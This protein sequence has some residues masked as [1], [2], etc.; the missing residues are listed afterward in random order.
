V[1]G[2]FLEDAGTVGQQDE[3]DVKAIKSG[4]LDNA[5]LPNDVCV[6]ATEDGDPI[7]DFLKFFWGVSGLLVSR[8]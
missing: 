4:S 1:F 7:S 5:F 3:P 6:K 8:S 2:G